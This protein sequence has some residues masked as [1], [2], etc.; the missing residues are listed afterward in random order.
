M[1][2]VSVEPDGYQVTGGFDC[3]GG[4]MTSHYSDVIMSAMASLITCVSI[5]VMLSKVD[6]LL[7]RIIYQD[8]NCTNDLSEMNNEALFHSGMITFDWHPDLWRR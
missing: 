3:L 6:G 8:I 7:E 5:V 1:T 4:D 2:D